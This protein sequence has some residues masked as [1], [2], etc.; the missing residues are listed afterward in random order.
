MT[1]YLGGRRKTRKRVS[2][3]ITREYIQ[4]FL[5]RLREIAGQHQLGAEP[6]RTPAS[7]VAQ[8][9]EMERRRGS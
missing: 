6:G 5:E 9:E 7:T 1:P 8:I 4:R 3:Y 2:P